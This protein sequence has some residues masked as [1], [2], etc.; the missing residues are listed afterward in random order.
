MRLVIWRGKRGPHLLHRAHELRGALS[1]VRGDDVRIDAAFLHEE[2]LEL[3]RAFRGFVG[4]VHLVEGDELGFVAD[5]LVKEENF[6]ADGVVLLQDVLAG[7]VED[8]H[9]HARA[10]DVAQKLEAEAD[11]LAG[12]LEQARDVGEDHALEIALDDAEVGNDG[13]EGVVRDL[14]LGVGDVAQQGALS[15]VGDADDAHVRHQLELHLDPPLLALLAVFGNL[16]R[17]VERRLERRVPAP[18]APAGED[19]LP[20]SVR[21]HLRENIP[22]LGI[23]NHRSGGHVHRFI[24]ADATLH[25]LPAARAA[26]LGA[27]MHLLAETHERVDRLVSLEIDGTAVATVTAV[28]S[29]LGDERL[30][31]ERHHAAAAVPGFDVDLRRVEAAHLA[32][33]AALA[34]RVVLPSV[35]ELLA[36]VELH[37]TAGL[38]LAVAHLELADSVV[39]L[40]LVVVGSRVENV[41]VVVV[42]VPVGLVALAKRHEVGLVA[43]LEEGLLLG[44]HLAAHL[45]A[46][47]LLGGRIASEVGERVGP[48]TPVGGFL[49]GGATAAAGAGA[50]SEVRHVGGREDGHGL[51]LRE[52]LRQALLRGRL[53]DGAALGRRR[54]RGGRPRRP[55]RRRAPGLTSLLRLARNGRRALFAA[56]SARAHHQRPRARGA[57]RARG[58]RGQPRGNQATPRRQHHVRRRESAARNVRPLG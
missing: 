49:R 8:V 26:R 23:A 9:E 3:Q 16:R 2:F 57:A 58:R 33:K 1:L 7:A 45:V 34:R 12:A 5:F 20:V 41:V 53:Q 47:R 15:R 13:S 38:A 14:G 32:G 42:V 10:L 37:C 27:M 18:A 31:A 52:N 21:E 19:H 28:R 55:L 39:I 24:R 56:A 6:V 30:A 54:R 43:E 35:V 29:A 36:E 17:L 51:V 11:A 48:R 44:E 40:P 25:A 22:S 4:D 46:R 50:E